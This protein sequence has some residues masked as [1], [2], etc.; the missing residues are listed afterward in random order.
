MNDGATAIFCVCGYTV[1][2][3]RQVSAHQKGFGHRIRMYAIERQAAGF[4]WIQMRYR[5]WFEG[6]ELAVE[7]GRRGSGRT[8]VENG[9]WVPLPLARIVTC[10]RDQITRQI[11]LKRFALIRE[12]ERPAFLHALDAAIR[13]SSPEDALDLIFDR[14]PGEPHEGATE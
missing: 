9:L 2:N 14:L 11:F 8:I 12:A 10:G 3:V 4:V 5:P 1:K 7:E 6:A 13:I